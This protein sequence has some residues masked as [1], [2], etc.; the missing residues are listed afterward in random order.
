MVEEKAVAVAEE[1]VPTMGE[2]FH[3]DPHIGLSDG[4]G[5]DTDGASEV[6]CNQRN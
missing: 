3:P 5:S 1:T 2:E 4:S 6:Q